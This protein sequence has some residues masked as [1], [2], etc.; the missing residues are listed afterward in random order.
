MVITNHAPVTQNLLWTCSQYGPLM[1]RLDSWC[2]EEKFLSAEWQVGLL[3][4]ARSF[5]TI[6]ILTLLISGRDT[7]RQ[8]FTNEVQ[9]TLLDLSPC[10]L[11]VLIRVS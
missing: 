4:F 6:K 9:P 5:C 3:W 11:S 8:E 1:G 10:C 7:I 2:R